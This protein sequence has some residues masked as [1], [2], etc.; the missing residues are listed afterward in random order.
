MDTFAEL[1]RLTANSIH[2]FEI[3][4]YDG[5]RLLII[6]SSHLSW[7][8]EVEILF[9][10]VVHI[11]CPTSFDTPTF[12][13]T[14]KCPC[15]ECRKFSIRTDQKEW[16]IIAG[17]AEVRIGIVYHYD[18]GENLQPGERIADWVSRK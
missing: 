16:E 11:N 18:R 4:S 15:C 12:Q 3:R 9:T 2:E 17:T 5:W 7:H 1:N 10:N 8:H 6:G 13:D 14:G